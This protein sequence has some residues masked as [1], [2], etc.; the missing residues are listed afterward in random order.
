LK[1]ECGGESD[2][3]N[4]ALR[5]APALIIRITH[6]HRVEKRER[7]LG[8]RKFTGMQIS[9]CALCTRTSSEEWQR[10]LRARAYCKSSQNYSSS[11]FIITKSILDIFSYNFERSIT[12]SLVISFSSL[13]TFAN[14]EHSNT[15]PL[16]IT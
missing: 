10:V 8:A 15:D 4:T 1:S 13:S 14:A 5:L 11:F 2:K 16:A 9:R 3:T 6:R 7:C 12:C